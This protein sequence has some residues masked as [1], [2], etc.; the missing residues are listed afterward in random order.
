MLLYKKSIF[1]LLLSFIIILLNHCANPVS[2]QGGKK[3]I[4]PPKPVFFFPPN[5]STSFHDRRIKITFD[6]FIQLK[7]PKT[8]ITISPPLLPNSDF[9]LHGKS[10]VIKMD[11]SLQTNTTF[12]FNFGESIS[13][14]TENNVLHDFSY[15][16][17]TG[18]HIDSL[19]L[20][21]KI[22][23][24]FDLT[25]QKDIFALL[26]INEN[27]TIPFDS[28]PCK[29]RSYYMARTNDKGEFI[30]HNLRNK[31][32]KLFALKD[33]NSNY[34]YDLSSEKVAFLDSLATGTFIPP[35][36]ADSTNKK[37]TLV[38]KDKPGRPDSAILKNKVEKKDTIKN[39]HISFPSYTL[40]LFEQ[41]DSTQKLL[42]SEMVQKNEV[43][44]VYK[45]PALDPEFT[46]LNFTPEGTWKIMEFSKKRDTV[47]LWLMS[48]PKDSL[49]VEIKDKGRKT[50]TVSLGLTVKSKKRRSSGKENEKPDRLDLG[51]TF[52]GGH[53]NQFWGDPEI[54]SSFP[55]SHAVFSRFLLVDNKD[56]IHVMANFRDSLKRNIIIH[57][58]WKEE[59]RYLLIIPDSV[60]FSINGLTNDSLKLDFQALALKN[61]GSIRMEITPETKSG[62]YIIQLLDDKENILRQSRIT[63]KEKIEFNY[64]FPGKYKIKAILDR[65]NNGRW[66]S[67][68][69]LKHLQ[70]EEV[71]YFPKIIEV[72]SNWDVEETWT[73]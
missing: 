54:I 2:P 3:D 1:F 48:I 8:K 49:I 36:F 5:F 59:A 53:L 22:I 31:P 39:G 26:Y 38:I 33:I 66:D 7:E 67:G 52:W 37:D 16:F 40:H 25:P 42:K 17:T 41:I 65:N 71:F 73:L 64:L 9:I 27:D 43:R 15:V 57:Y 45:F 50:D 68:I 4:I 63:Q 13:D 56:T 61:F 20:K 10:L 23:D 51:T 18:T 72:R 60:L 11:D 70:P 58:K 14:L 34:L 24:A 47:L 19:S 21:G 69:Y 55:L 6:E 30:L 46:P 12:S 35:E 32:Y 44:F 62:T 29:V 28:L